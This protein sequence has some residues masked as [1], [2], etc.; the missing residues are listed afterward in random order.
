MSAALQFTLG[1]VPVLVASV[2]LAVLRKKGKTVWVVSSVCLALLVGGGIFAAAKDLDRSWDPFTSEMTLRAEE[3]LPDESKSS[4]QGKDDYLGLVRT[5]LDDG[6]VADAERFLHEYAETGGYGN[7][8]LCL[9]ALVDRAKGMTDQAERLASALAKRGVSASR[10]EN[11]GARPNE[12]TKSAAEV[13]RYVN[14]LAAYSR[15]DGYYGHYDMETI[16]PT[17]RQWLEN[18]AP[19]SSLPTMNRVWLAAQLYLQNY[20]SLANDILRNPSGDSLI[21]VSQL[22]R[23][24]EVNDRDLSET[25][26]SRQHKIDARLVLEWV[27]KQLQKRE[28]YT[29]SG[30]ETLKNAKTELTQTVEG[31]SH[32]F[33]TY[34]KDE[35][36]SRAAEGG[37]DGSKLYLELAD[38]AYASG[39]AD[40]AA[41]YLLSGLA[42]APASDDKTYASAANAINQIMN[43]TSDPEARKQLS[44]YAAKLDK[45][46]MPELVPPITGEN[47]LDEQIRQE[48]SGAAPSQPSEPETDWSG[49]PTA[50]TQ[51]HETD[52]SQGGSSGTGTED[53]SFAQNVTNTLNQITGSISIVSV[54]TSAFPKLT[55]TVAVDDSLAQ[56]AED[57]SLHM[58]VT[59]T[60]C[61]IKNYTVEKVNY[62]G[63]NI[64]L[65][66]DDSGSMSGS[67]RDDLN[68]A[69]KAFVNNAQGNM[70]I[71][72]VPF[73]DGVKESFVCYPGAS[74]SELISA[75]DQLRA[76]GG[77]DIY[78]AVTYA[79]ALF[80]QDPDRL[81]IMIIM[82]DGQE[83][84]TPAPERMEE[85]R[86][87]CTTRGITLYTVGLGYDVDAAQLENYSDYGGGSYYYVDSSDA[88]LAFYQ[89]IYD[90]S[91]NRYK[92]SFDAVDTFKVDRALEVR[93][94]NAASIVGILNYSLYR[95][96]LDDREAPEFDVTMGDVLI[97]GLQERMIYP[98]NYAQTATLLGSGFDKDAGVE[99]TLHGVKDYPCT[100]QYK[101]ENSC[102]VTIPGKVPVGLYDVY[103]T[104][105]GRRAVFSSGLIVAGG[106]RH[107]VRFG[108]YVFT[109]TTVTETDNRTELSGVV[110]MNDWLGFT[111]P[112]VLTGDLKNDYQIRMDFGKT[113]MQYTDTSLPGLGGFYARHGYTTHLPQVGSLTLCN[114]QT[115]SGSDENYPVHPA[116]IDN[117]NV[118]DFLAI[119]RAG[120][121]LYPDRAMINF[122]EFSTKLPFQDKILSVADSKH[123]FRYTLDL[124]TKLFYSKDRIDCS[125]E[126]SY[127][128]TDTGNGMKPLKLGN[129]AMYVNPASVELKLNTMTGNNSIKFTADVAMLC[130]GVGLEVVWKEW[131]LDEITLMADYK[132]N[133]VIYGIPLTFDDFKIGFHDISDMDL[134]KDW[135][136]FFNMEVTGSVD[137]S[138][139]KISAYCKGLE[140]Y[141]GDV[142]LLSLDDTTLGLR[143]RSPR[144]RL[145][146]TAK[147]L[148]LVE[149]GHLSAQVGYGL[150]YT[151]PLFTVQNAPNGIIL[152]VGLGFKLEMDNFNVNLGGSGNL[153][154]TDQA[155]GLLMKGQVK[156]DIR[157]W[158]FVKE[159]D[160]EGSFY[161]GWYRQHNG[162]FGF[163]ILAHG[164][165]SNGK[166]VSFSLPWADEPLSSHKF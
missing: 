52:P 128:D 72:F 82:S 141:V 10:L 73:A 119:A 93:Y 121:S 79:T 58:S 27:K 84:Y 106:D 85:L 67:K 129:N 9:T 147:L 87:A 16:L 47:V 30:Y 45:N 152:E 71:G 99:V 75:A 124:D 46:R 62:T 117:Y 5:L 136:T 166:N 118:L 162:E 59:D 94:N 108:E 78:D 146:T 151:N 159:Y 97:H 1:L 120:L 132:I 112:V 36:L 89:Y 154:I 138:L 74:K 111:D 13:Y 23:K 148:D 149:L 32:E 43:A 65:V 64:I 104:Y 68:A 4:E 133:K 8:Y 142:S 145:E 90:L 96:D 24:G 92:L 12:D 70:Q 6:R 55:A 29:E 156:A 164:Q 116:S 122:N 91:V 127:G 57:F 160:A 126:F 107:V 135:T 157:W 113:Y 31:T 50:E 77:T 153:A 40:Q 54:D 15:E 83:N 109:A 143:L 53:Q 61:A 69:V 51:P 26:K 101:D 155:I 60:D 22:L 98:T 17:L 102:T 11:V 48:N 139:A 144:L 88:I 14:D 150:D 134:E 114:D 33:Y 161:L 123:F 100:V 80:P 81:N 19:C 18:G 115:I 130:D 44:E 25:A 39:D 2:L 35:M 165:T 86:T 3:T 49:S 137:I 76:S 163:N 41:N 21:V 38:I 20:R 140:K 34:V 56:S 37:E 95:N 66:C 158:V 125:L 131:K 42:A 110:I 63:V 7:D 105:N 103:V 28:K